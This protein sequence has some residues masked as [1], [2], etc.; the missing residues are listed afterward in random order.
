[1]VQCFK[2]NVVV[3][4]SS[5]VTLTGCLLISSDARQKIDAELKCGIKSS[6]DEQVK[7]DCGFTDCDQSFKTNDALKRRNSFGWQIRIIYLKEMV[8]ICM[9]EQDI[10]VQLLFFRLSTDTF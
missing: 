7:I 10:L 9:D 6:P 1:M 8:I 3:F 5:A 4:R 2:L